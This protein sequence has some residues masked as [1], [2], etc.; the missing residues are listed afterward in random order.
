MFNLFDCSFEGVL[1]D[2]IEVKLCL[3]FH[4]N[5][6]SGVKVNR[7]YTHDC[8]ADRSSEKFFDAIIDGLQNVNLIM[9]PIVGAIF[10]LP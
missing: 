1:I 3:Y 2:L 8:L 10:N 5:D 6:M 4:Q 7:E 9:N